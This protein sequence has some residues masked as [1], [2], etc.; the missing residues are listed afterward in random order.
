MFLK[1]FCPVYSL[2]FEFQETNSYSRLSLKRWWQGELPGHH[3]VHFQK[4]LWWTRPTLQLLPFKSHLVQYPHSHTKDSGTTDSRNASTPRWRQLQ[5]PM[6]QESTC[7][8]WQRGG[9]DAAPPQQAVTPWVRPLWPLGHLSVLPIPLHKRR[10]PSVWT[11]RFGHVPFL[12]APE[13][14][15]RCHCAQRWQSAFMFL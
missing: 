11:A 3:F 1:T 10:F 5:W 12:M 13:A 2:N 7:G 15:F 8:W 4:Q 6:W 14:Y 9:G